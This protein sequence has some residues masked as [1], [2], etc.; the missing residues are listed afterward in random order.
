[1]FDI[2]AP[3]LSQAVQVYDSICTNIKSSIE[4]GFTAV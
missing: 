1:M 4:V 2:G 3:M